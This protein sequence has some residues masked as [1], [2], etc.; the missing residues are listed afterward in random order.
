[1]EFELATGR[2]NRQ[3]RSQP[4]AET[5]GAPRTPV[6]SSCESGFVA[7]TIRLSSNETVYLCGYTGD[8]VLSVLGP[9]DGSERLRLSPAGAP[10]PHVAGD[11]LLLAGVEP[12]GLEA[13]SLV[14]GEKL[15]SCTAPE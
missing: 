12:Q 4:R 8:G 13:Y 14:T 2:L 5:G 9:R 10:I 11:Y 15:W 7:Q 3:W 6:A 1:M